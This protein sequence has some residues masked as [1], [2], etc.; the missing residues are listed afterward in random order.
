MSSRKDKGE[1]HCCHDPAVGS[2]LHQTLDEM[3]FERGL[4]SAALSGDIEKT[5]QLLSRTDCDVNA[6]DT[7]S[8]TA[9]VGGRTFL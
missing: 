1:K 9:L 6:L 4:W 7:S 5:D 2:S 8:Y 3:D